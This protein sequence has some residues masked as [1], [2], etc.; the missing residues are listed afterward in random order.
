MYELNENEYRNIEYFKNLHRYSAPDRLLRYRRS[1][2]VLGGFVLF[3]YF[4]GITV[5]GFSGG[6]MKGTIERPQFVPAFL[7]F[8]FLYN[9][10]MFWLY[11]RREI[12]THN[13][14]VNSLNAFGIGV[15]R[16]IIKREIGKY[17]SQSGG[18]GEYEPKN[19]SMH[20]GSE[21]I[22]QVQFTLDPEL[23]QKHEKEIQGLPGF[24]LDQHVINFD[25]KIS[26][27]DKKFYEENKDFL[28]SI[29]VHEF[30]DYKAPKYFGLF[31]A[32]VIIVVNMSA[33]V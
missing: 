14:R 5:D 22:V 30:M 15:A 13:F 6:F 11:L 2:I 27:T 23:R 25:Y 32:L 10:Y 4:S 31:V 24:K 8:F 28:K 1:V 12:S 9:F 29:L 7:S 20:G 19:F 26:D 18:R 16:Y 3:Y 17:F 21:N 33:V